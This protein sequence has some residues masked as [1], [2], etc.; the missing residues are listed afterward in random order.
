[1]RTDHPTEDEIRA[2]F[3]QML[4]SVCGGGGLRTDTGLDTETADALWAIARAHPRVTEDLVRAARAEFA[5]QLDGSH[6]RARREALARLSEELDR[7]AGR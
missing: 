4:D 1:M 2:E 7:K 3:E 5:A 6:R